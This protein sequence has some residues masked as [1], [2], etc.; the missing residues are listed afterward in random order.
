MILDLASLETD[1]SVSTDVLIIGGGIAGLLLAARLR[2]LAVPV[3]V[4]ES[5]AREQEDAEHPLNRVVQ[6][7]QTYRGATQ[8]RFRCLGGTSTRWGGALIPFLDADLAA[9]PH[10]DLPAW[11]ITFAELRPHIAGIETLF[12]ID[13]GSYEENFVLA[14]G[15]GRH[16]PMGDPDFL[17]RFAKWPPFKKRNVATLLAPS[18]EG[19]AGLSIYLN[20]TATDFARDAAGGR[21]ASVTARHV[22]GRRITVSARQVVVC[23]G[24]I[25]STRLL[26]LL[27]AQHDNQVFASCTA[28]GRTFHDHVSMPAAEIVA[29]DV[30]RLNRMAGF[31]FVGATMRS[32]RFELAPAAQA[33]D[34]VGSAFGHIAFASERETGFDALRQ[35]LRH[36]QRKGG[37]DV[38]AA[39]KVLQDLPY[40]AKLIYWR[41]A[42]RQLYWPVPARYELHIVAEQAPR[43]TNRISLAGE[44]DAFGC[45]LAAIDWRVESPE[46]ATIAAFA[47]RFDAYWTRHGLQSLGDLH[48]L[49]DLSSEPATGTFGGSDVFHP[50]GTTRMGLDATTAVV[51]RDLRTFAVP[52][53]WV[54]STSVFPSGAS[55][56]PTMMLMLLTSRL[57]ARLGSELARR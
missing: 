5:G 4:L 29:R 3:V 23:A 38:K 44:T 21:L 7:S 35:F 43:A 13:R 22:G 14:G 15:V 24:A 19:D 41:G 49:V 36:L 56:N 47:R 42:H 17:A 50:G 46:R 8:G 6:L 55:A 37:I 30:A 27:D 12:G 40:L 45:P 34:R 11:P 28:L 10:L 31:R 52:N 20:A 39:L 48:W 33:A 25:E 57:A 54:A 51:D 1:R 32:L 9:R 26:L 2:D 53:L 18:I 16:V